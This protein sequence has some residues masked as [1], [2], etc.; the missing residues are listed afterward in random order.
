MKSVKLDAIKLWFALPAD[1]R[2]RLQLSKMGRWSFA[3]RLRT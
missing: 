3:A 2:I 1:E